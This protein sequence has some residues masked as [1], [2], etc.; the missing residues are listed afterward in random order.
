MESESAGFT[1]VVGFM[2]H[3]LNGQFLVPLI[4]L[5][6]LLVSFFAKVPCGRGCYCS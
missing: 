2:I 6:L 3:G 1:G 5:L 4:G